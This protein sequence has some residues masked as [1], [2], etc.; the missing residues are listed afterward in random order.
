VW[1]KAL[2]TRGDKKASPLWGSS[3]LARCFGTCDSSVVLGKVGRSSQRQEGNGAGDGERLHE[4][5]NA[6]KGE[7]HERIRHET[8]P[9]G[10][11]R[12]KA[13][14]GRENLEAQAIGLGTP[15][16]LMPLP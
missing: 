2:K 7:P 10:S 16:H 13:P 5:S 9:A 15:D 11:R 8:R 6:L 12:I 4:R 3:G 1:S 14:G